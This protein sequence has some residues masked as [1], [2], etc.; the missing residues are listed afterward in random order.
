M[1][2]AVLLKVSS[3]LPLHMETLQALDDKPQSSGTS[4][5]SVVWLMV[6]TPVCCLLVL[7]V[8]DRTGHKGPVYHCFDTP[9][10]VVCLIA[11]KMLMPS[12]RAAKLIQVLSGRYYKTTC[13]PNNDQKLKQCLCFRRELFSGV[14]SHTSGTEHQIYTDRTDLGKWEADVFSVAICILR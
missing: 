12:Q 4:C 5:G 1:D 8:A 11:Y 13:L 6:L 7:F 9:C 2:I 14:T 3:H 10:T